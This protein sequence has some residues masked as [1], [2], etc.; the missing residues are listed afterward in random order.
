VFDSLFLFFWSGSGT[1][2]IP[3]YV[4]DYRL[5][6]PEMFA[7]AIGTSFRP[8]IEPEN[9]STITPELNKIYADSLATFLNSR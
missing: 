8:Q 9:F 1:E 7:R 5:S 4:K 6:G 3:E 2:G